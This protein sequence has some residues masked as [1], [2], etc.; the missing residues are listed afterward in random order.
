MNESMREGE[1]IPIDVF[2]QL[3]RKRVGWTDDVITPFAR[4]PVRADE[5]PKNPPVDVERPPACDIDR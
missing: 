3:L 1:H 4:R 2:E 5:P